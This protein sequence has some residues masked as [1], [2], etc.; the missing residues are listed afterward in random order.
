MCSCQENPR[1][2]GAWWAAI[3]GAAQSRTRL[4]QLSS[5]MWE[6][7]LD[8]NQ[9][10]S[11]I[12]HSSDYH[13]LILFGPGS[14]LHPHQSLLIFVPVTSWGA[15]DGSPEGWPPPG[16]ACLRPH[17]ITQC[18]PVSAFPVCCKSALKT[19]IHS[20]PSLREGLLTTPPSGC[21]ISGDTG[22]ERRTF[23]PLLSWVL[24][25]G[26]IIKW[27]QDRVTGGKKKKR[28]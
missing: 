26:L 20:G 28:I 24:W 4:K 6:A 14:P 1:D 2:G 10:Q 25:A 19:W 23:P 16:H 3:Y 8:L 17:K 18:S 21:L 22:L 7:Q 15:Q 11:N 27:M 12:S 13:L 9:D 5:S